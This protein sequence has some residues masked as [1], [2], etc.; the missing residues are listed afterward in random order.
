[1]TTRF[2]V[3]THQAAGPHQSGGQLLHTL[4]AAPSAYSRATAAVVHSKPS[5][6][7]LPEQTS[8]FPQRARLLFVNEQRPESLVVCDGVHPW[9]LEG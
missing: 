3:R 4:H 2:S 8:Q 1:M 9:K 7:V 6:G 5:T